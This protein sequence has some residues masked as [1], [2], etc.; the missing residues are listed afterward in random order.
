MARLIPHADV[1]D[2]TLKPERDVA[3]AL[4]DTLPDDCLV[5]HSFPWLRPERNDRG[6]ELYLREGEADFLVLS[7]LGLLVLEV[8]G[9]EIRYEPQ[10]GRWYRLLSSGLYNDIKDP[11]RQASDNM[12]ALVR[13]ILER[14]F[15][16]QSSLPCGYGYAVVFPDCRW[17]GTTPP[18]ADRSIVLDSSDLPHLGKRI[19]SLVQRW[20]RNPNPAPLEGAARQRVRAGLAGTFRLLPALDR[21]VADQEAKLVQ[22]TDSQAAALSGLYAN[23]R[24]VVSGPAGSGKTMLAVATAKHLAAQGKRVLLLCFNRS[25][26]EWLREI[27]PRTDFPTIS[28]FT[29]NALCAEWCRR[30]G[31]R[32]QVPEASSE[33]QAFFRT[34]AAELLC[35]ASDAVEEKFD[36]VIVD[37]AQDFEPEWWTPIEFLNA[38]EEEGSLYIFHD[39]KQNLFV[40]KKLIFPGNAARFDLPVNCRN[41]RRIAAY[42][43][44][45]RG[46]EIPSAAFSPEG[47]DPKL[48]VIPARERRL[49]A[50]EQQLK[51]WIRDGNLKASQVAVLSPYRSDSPGCSVGG[52]PKLAG[53]SVTSDPARWRDGEGVLVTTIRSFKGLEADAVILTDVS[54]PSEGAFSISDLYVAS[55]RAKHFL[56]IYATEP[57]DS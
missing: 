29:F 33:R 13:T 48:E 40:N 2:I 18:G 23:E 9:G 15:P 16:G 28:V 26:A 42:C 38:N 19:A 24:L 6:R 56:T 11:F 52:R 45:V 17:D 47:R 49:T 22:L 44:K 27:L 50:V 20:S 31:L 54:R 35:E 7:P 25:L 36:A 39:P 4:V 12:H 3:Q 1:S 55:S 57:I 41:T 53:L 5:Y 21:L 51:E 14:E 30:A 10:T 37:E 34:T 46:V 32:F 8:K 43:S